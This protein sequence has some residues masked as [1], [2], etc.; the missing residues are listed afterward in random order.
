VHCQWGRKSNPFLVIGDAA[1]GKHA[2]GPSHGHKQHAQ[3]I[4]GKDRAC[5]SGDIL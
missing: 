4:I 5:G 2:G 3:K 1:Y